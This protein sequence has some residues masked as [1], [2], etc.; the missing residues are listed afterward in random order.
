MR[1]RLL[2]TGLAG[3]AL[4]A[5]GPGREPATGGS[6]VE[7][8]M[9]DART[10]WSADSTDTTRNVWVALHYPEF[11]SAPGPAALDSLNGWVS[12]RLFV[13]LEGD[14]VT[15]TVN[16]LAA[17]LIRDFQS[18][19]EE[20][21]TTAAT[22]W[23]VD[24]EVAV[25][26]DSLDVVSMEAFT[27]RYMGGAHGETDRTWGVLHAGSGRGLRVEDVVDPGALDTLRQMGEAA[28]RLA[29]QLAPGASLAR[30]GFEFEDGRFRLTPNFGVSPAGFEFGY[31]ACEVAP[32]LFGPTEIRLSWDAVRPLLRQD[33]PLGALRGE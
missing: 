32:C 27:E 13:L 29:R 9:R 19:R 24:A 14:T 2:L 8:T 1:R 11:T 31:R 30:A 25:K 20:T 28:F 33:G 17:R 26:W 15:P 23:Y 21:G 18:F 6:R 4:F 5:C 7:W 10:S 3:L 12:R 22:P 16:G